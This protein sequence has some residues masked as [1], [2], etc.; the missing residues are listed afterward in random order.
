MTCREFAEFIAQYLASELPSSQREAFDRHLSLCT[1]CARYL[2]QYQRTIAVSRTAF[3][4]EAPL[5][6]DVPDDLVDAILRARK[7]F[8]Q[9]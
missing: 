1:N 3:D 5:P 4:T 8:S 9:D 6:A 7:A 2:E